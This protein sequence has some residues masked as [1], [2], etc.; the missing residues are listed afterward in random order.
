M[1]RVRLDCPIGS[2]AEAERPIIARVL[3]SPAAAAAALL[4][5]YRN[6]LYAEIEKYGF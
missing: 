2:F 4:R 1:P 5:T 6:Q 3:K